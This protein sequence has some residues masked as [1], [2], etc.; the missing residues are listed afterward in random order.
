MSCFYN[1]L[2]AVLLLSIVLEKSALT[3]AVLEEPI[4]LQP[5]VYHSCYSHR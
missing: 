2:L 5:S 3:F 1:G 4:V